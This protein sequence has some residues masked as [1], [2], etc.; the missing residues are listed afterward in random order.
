MNTNANGRPDVQ[1]QTTVAASI[2]AELLRLHGSAGVA[3]RVGVQIC[4]GDETAGNHGLNH[5][6]RDVRQLRRLGIESIK[7][8]TR[9]VVPIHEIAAWC[10]GERQPTRIDRRRREHRHLRAA[11][12]EVRHG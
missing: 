2:A 9:W 5:T 8:G 3:P 6:G 7:V 11:G 1:P 4:T 12:G 10:A